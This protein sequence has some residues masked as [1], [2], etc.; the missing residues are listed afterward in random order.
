MD[1]REKIV[2]LVADES[3]LKYVDEINDTIQRA[4]EERGTGI[5][6]RTYDYVA[7]KMKEGKAIIALDGEKF[8]GFCYIESWGHHKFV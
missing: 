7:T 5:A 2:V 3:H 4:S 8:A 1:E 6:R